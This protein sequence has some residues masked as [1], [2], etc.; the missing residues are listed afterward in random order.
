VRPPGLVAVPAAV[1]ALAG[2]GGGDGSTT[3]VIQTTT[4]APVQP[5]T[6]ET[7]ATPVAS[8]FV[9]TIDGQR[10]AQPSEIPFSV[11]GDL[12]GTDLQ[13]SDWGSDS[14]TA[15]GTFVFDAAPHTNPTSVPGTL[16]VSGLVACA[17]EGYYTSA[18]LS[19]TQQP[20]F[21]PQVPSFTVPCD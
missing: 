5:T 12:V 10:S 8:V 19:F 17:D 11:N 18:R 4:T 2:C 16:T 9:Q 1:L 7:A 21:Q 15:Q 14:A 6:T 13:W 20:P 3:T